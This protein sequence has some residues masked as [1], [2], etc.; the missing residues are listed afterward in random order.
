MIFKPELADLILAGAKTETR[1]PV[2]DNPR[3]PWWRG[4]AAIPNRRYRVGTTFAVQRGRNKNGEAR[5]LV[6]ERRQE[7]LAVV[8]SAGARA[9]G[10]ETRG[11][12][13][14]YI[15]QLHGSLDLDQPVWVIRFELV[16]VSDG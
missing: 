1:R 6:L 4:S 2:S 8:S 13:L 11:E 7:P 3:S 10:F 12:F 9:E 14:D 16:E 5:A 15:E